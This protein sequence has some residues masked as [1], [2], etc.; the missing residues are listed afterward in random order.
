MALEAARRN[1]PRRLHG[2]ATPPPP[3]AAGPQPHDE[4][5]RQTKAARGVLQAP[6]LPLP[7]VT[8]DC[9]GCDCALARARGCAACAGTNNKKSKGR[10]Q[11]LMPGGCTA[12]STTGTVPPVAWHGMVWR[13]VPGDVVCLWYMTGTFGRIAWASRPAPLLARTLPAHRAQAGRGI[14]R[15]AMPRGG[16]SRCA[17][18]LAY[19]GRARTAPQA[20]RPR[21][22]AAA[23]A[24][25]LRNALPRG[26]T[27]TGR[28]RRP[29]SRY[30][31][32]RRLAKPLAGTVAA[33]L[34]EC[35]STPSAQ[36]HTA[37][38]PTTWH[39]RRLSCAGPHHG[40]A[41][42]AHIVPHTS[43]AGLGECDPTAP[44]ALPSRQ[45]QRVSRGAA[46]CRQSAHPCAETPSVRGVAS[47]WH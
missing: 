15:E 13:T 18:P 32:H 46:R 34:G 44:T 5:R 23:G 30:A 33:S 17:G 28:T 8:A 41:D 22:R 42:R 14:C 9:G 1:R 47:G 40:R 21:L 4:A 7:A 31:R 3:A 16:E 19:G 20:P 27:A 2:D 12:F 38:P 24:P 35:R 25:Q 6:A 10:L 45:L 29:E 39:D 43:Q 11:Y 26:W 36:S 37:G